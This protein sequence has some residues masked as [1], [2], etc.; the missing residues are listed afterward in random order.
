MTPLFALHAQDLLAITAVLL[1]WAAL[2]WL[3]K[4]R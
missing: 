4:R 1:L 2:R 3:T